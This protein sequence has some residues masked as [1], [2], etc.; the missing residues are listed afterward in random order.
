MKTTKRFFNLLAKDRKDLVY[1][2]IYASLQGLINLSLPVGIQAIMSLVLAGR[3]SASWTILTII[4]TGG[5]VLAGVFQIL[6]LYLVEILQRKLFVRSAFEFAYRIPQFKIRNLGTSYAPEIVHRFFDVVGVQ[7]NLNKTL[8]DFSSSA[9]QI[10]FGLILL[11][12]Y[13]PVFIA[14]GLALLL[15]LILIIAFSF[16]EGLKSSIAESDS[17]YQTAYWLTE[18]AR[19]LSTFKL[20]GSKDMVLNQ[21]DLVSE[22]YL[23]NR[24]RHFRIVVKQLISILSLKTL[25]TAGLL[26]IGALLLINNS[27]TI[28]QFVAS[29]IVII[30]VLSSTEKLIASMES[31]YDLLTSV[32]KLG[33]VTDLPL[34]STNEQ[35]VDIPYGEAMSVSVK[36]LSI[37]GV[38]DNKPIIKGLSFDIDSKERVCIVGKSGTGKSTLLKTI[39]S[40]TDSYDGVIS[41]NGVPMNNIKIDSFR[42]NNRVIFNDQEIFYG[43]LIDNVGMQN[44]EI[45]TQEIINV[46]DQVGLR[47]LV[48]RLPNGYFETITNAERMLS[49]TD[50]V[51]LI[52]ARALINKPGLILAEDLFSDLD[53][54]VMKNLVDTLMKGCQNSTLIIASNQQEIIARCTRIIDLNS[55]A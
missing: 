25:V 4:V 15:I 42:S 19:S 46:L 6:Q 14:F 48:E 51:R 16:K 22:K 40:F 34:D 37:R 47:P 8:L 5:V 7:K 53:S 41:I 12:L 35:G 36:D 11:S 52:T 10:V 27:I 28:G 45:E 24:K 50:R 18:I 23:T 49:K 31:I 29:E 30:L 32:E 20:V 13:H 43:S 3:L 21:T 17:K 2:Y 44:P 9:M 38:L 54:E 26:I 39:S 1:L 33:K 55:Y